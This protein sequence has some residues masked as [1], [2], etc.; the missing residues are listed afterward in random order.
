MMAAL[1]GAIFG[2]SVMYILAMN[3]PS[4]IRLLFTHV[5]LI[6]I[7]LIND[8]ATQL[9]TNGLSTML[10]GPLKGT[11]YK[12]YAAQAGEQS[13]PFLPFLFMTIPARLERFFPVVLAFGSLGKRF[14][15]F[16]KENTWFVVGSYALLWGVIYIVFITYFGF[17]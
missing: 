6:D 11:P 3:D 9:R 13:L 16:C 14:E 2:G 5:P 1:V 17:H 15:T 4:S 10:T 12:I 8:V 7:E